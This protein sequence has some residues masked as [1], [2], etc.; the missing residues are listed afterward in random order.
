VRPKRLRTFDY[1]GCH[2]YVLTF[3]TYCR[4][5]YFDDAPL[6]RL[7]EAQLFPSAAEHHF[8]ELAYCFMP[9]HLHMLVAGMR[10]DSAFVP[11]AKAV[12]QRSA[13]EARNARRIHLW[14]DGFFE[15]VLRMDEELVPVARYIFENPVRGGL[16]AEAKNWPYSGGR[17]W[18]LYAGCPN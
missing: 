11:F 4:N 15:R 2:H 7:V 16:I 9:D 13:Y 1:I 12:R 6:V 10:R 18:R 5:R 3:W 14:Q 8:A 17:Y